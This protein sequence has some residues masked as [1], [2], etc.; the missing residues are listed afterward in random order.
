MKKFISL[1]L[2]LL[3]IFSLCS[4]KADQ[5]QD[6]VIVSPE[7]QSPLPA[8]DE[9]IY[10]GTDVASSPFVGSF[11]NS[12][13]ALFKS[14]AQDVFKQITQNEDESFTETTLEKPVLTCNADGTFTL[15]VCTSVGE[16]YVMMN[17]IFTVDGEYGEFRFDEAN[18]GDFLGSD[19]A[20][21][22]LQLK[23]KTDLRYTGEQ[24]GTITAGDIFTRIG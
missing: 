2:A 9:P 17:G 23:N 22:W 4:C 6:P 12:Y 15:K 18:Y 24:I 3:M 11:E 19:V 8:V 14:A 20:V 5:K 10:E 16:D 21:F 1:L 13:V 7:E